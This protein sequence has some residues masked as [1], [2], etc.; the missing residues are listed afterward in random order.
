MIRIEYALL[1]LVEGAPTLDLLDD[2]ERERAER[3]VSEEARARFVRVRTALRAELGHRLRVPPHELRFS[4]GTSGKPRLAAPFDRARVEFSV[5]HTRGLAL[6]AFS[7]GA[8]VG[9]DLE[10]LRELHAPRAL[11]QRMLSEHENARLAR[12][13]GDAWTD[14][15]LRLWTRKEALVKCVGGSI[16]GP[17]VEERGFAFAEVPAPPGYLAAVCAAGSRL[18]LVERPLYSAG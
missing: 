11:A 7:E 13:T 17:A 8:A 2:V 12:L 6:L 16:L 10:R 4:Y 1:P 9:A 5:A 3:F 15:F 18:M 14:A